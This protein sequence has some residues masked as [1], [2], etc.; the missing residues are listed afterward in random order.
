MARFA[1]EFYQN[2]NKQNLENQ[3]QHLTNY[4]IQKHSPKFERNIDA[5][6][7]HKGHKRSY[8]SVLD[9]IKKLGH[10]TTKLENQIKDLIIK[11]ICIVQPHL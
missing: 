4:S 2:P 10:S 6:E 1:T 7:T 3:Y 9:A 8:T 11:T 5:N